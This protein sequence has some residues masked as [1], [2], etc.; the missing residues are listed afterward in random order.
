MHNPVGAVGYAVLGLGLDVYPSS[1][2]VGELKYNIPPEII[3]RN[4][5]TL[6][7]QFPHVSL[8]DWSS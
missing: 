6:Q 7:P 4:R 8:S 2:V 5:L 1:S 3:R